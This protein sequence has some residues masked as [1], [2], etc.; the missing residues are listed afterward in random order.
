MCRMHHA[1]KSGQ[2]L[3]N[4]VSGCSITVSAG[5]ARAAGCPCSACQQKSGHSERALKEACQSRTDALHT[6]CQI[7]HGAVLYTPDQQLHRTSA[8]QG[9]GTCSRRKASRRN[10]CCALASMLDSQAGNLNCGGGGSPAAARASSKR[11]T[12]CSRRSSV[13]AA[14][15]HESVGID[16]RPRQLQPSSFL[17]GCVRVARSQLLQCKIVALQ[18]ERSVGKHSHSTQPPQPPHAPWCGPGRR[19]RMALEYSRN[20]RIWSLSSPAASRS[21]SHCCCIVSSRSCARGPLSKCNLLRRLP[22]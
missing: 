15:H 2:R 9:S 6:S 3:L 10:R 22:L 14:D 17:L 1:L 13:S 20:S 5:C 19:F 12:S 7:L 18:A 11:L 8:M 4:L 21:R 16:A